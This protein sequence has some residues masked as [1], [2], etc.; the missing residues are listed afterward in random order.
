ML[1]LKNFKTTGVIKNL[2]LYAPNK[3][4]YMTNQF[5]ISLLQEKVII[6][7]GLNTEAIGLENEDFSGEDQ[8]QYMYTL[9]FFPYIFF[10]KCK[11]LF[12]F[13]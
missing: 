5:H 3:G 9:R 1:T 10:I 2:H 13:F 12:L 4:T 7:W 6:D 8:C 11:Y